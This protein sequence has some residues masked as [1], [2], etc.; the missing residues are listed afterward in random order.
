MEDRPIELPDEVESKVHE[1]MNTFGLI[2]GALDF[3]VTPEGRFVFLEI[4][5]AGQYMWVES[6][7]GLPI[8]NALADLLSD[9]C[10]A[11]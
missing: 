7:T 4:N 3:I 9:A 5:P 6:R 8:T 11:N 2:Y 10:K 1:L